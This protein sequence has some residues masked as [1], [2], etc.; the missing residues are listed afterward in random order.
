[1]K[2]LILVSEPRAAKKIK[3]RKD[4]IVVSLNDSTSSAMRSEF[5][6]FITVSD[7]I[8]PKQA[9]KINKDSMLW[10]KRWSDTSGIKNIT[11]RNISL[12]WFFD[13]WLYDSFFK[14]D[15]TKNMIWYVSSIKAIIKKVNPKKVIV[16]GNNIVAYIVQQLFDEAENNI[17]NNHEIMHATFIDYAL[18]AK[19]LIRKWLVKARNPKM[20]H[21]DIIFSTYT[22][23][24]RE[25]IKE[26]GYKIKEDS[27]LGYIIRKADKKYSTMVADIDYSKKLEMSK[28]PFE[29]FFTSKIKRY[30]R[31][32][33]KEIYKRWKR[34]RIKQATYEGVDL[35]PLLKPWLDFAFKRRTFLAILY[36][37]GGLE[38][39]DYLAPKLAFV[40]DETGLYGR[41]IVT[42]ARIKQIP[43]IAVQHGYI[44]EDSFEYMHIKGEIGHRIEKPLC[45]IADKTV[46]Y[47]P[48]TKEILIK[49]G[50]YPADKVEVTGQP[51]YDC[52]VGDHL[53]KRRVFRD[54]DLDRNK[55]LILWTT[56]DVPGQADI[57]FRA[58]KGMKDAQLLVKL[59]PRELGGMKPYYDKAEE[60][61]IKIKAVQEGNTL[62][63]IYACDTI[64]TM[65]STT[66][67]EAIMMGKPV[68]VLNTSGRP[69]MVPYVS[70]GAAL[71]VYRP[72][73][74]E[75]A[76]RKALFDRKTISRLKKN[77][78]KYA[79]KHSYKMD[80]KATQ[81]VMKVAENLMSGK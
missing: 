64:I 70:E 7:F 62:E 8:T 55:K 28:F 57:V 16:H 61:G 46:V 38:M 31:K 63:M 33:C 26:D 37:E 39:Y 73:D 68:V 21:K 60:L 10:L 5:L 1:M 29:Y 58:V 12:W 49:Q 45:P 20:T 2:T 27:V 13:F 66:G 47:G 54:I 35:L 69:D 76:L 36:I 75:K 11:Y 40:I 77:S 41:S 43:I 51:R 23:W 59:H 48:Y 79:Y 6:N 53:R 65:H 4:D 9:E 72:E 56:Q 67:L 74:L 71:G 17:Y 24:T 25:V 50:N 15:M 78:R 14:W 18:K 44:T 3:S 19:H 34:A 52:L 22:S 81:R 42:A 30:A 32:K 80:G